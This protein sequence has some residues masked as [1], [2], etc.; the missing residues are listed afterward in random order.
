MRTMPDEKIAKLV[1]TITREE[2]QDEQINKETTT[3]KYAE[4]PE[5]A[6]PIVA[7]GS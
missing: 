1:E 6:S 2:C 7:A 3:L 4:T 5:L